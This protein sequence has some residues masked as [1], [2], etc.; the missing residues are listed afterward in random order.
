MRLKVLV[1]IVTMCFA[2]T[3]FA[4]GPKLTDQ[5]IKAS[6]EKQNSDADIDIIKIKLG[7][8]N[9][10][11]NNSINGAD[12]NAGRMSQQYY[13]VYQA[14]ANAGVIAISKD[15]SYQKFKSGGNFN[16]MDYNS[17]IQ[18]VSDKIVVTKTSEGES[19]VGDLPQEDGWL[20]IR[21]AKFK[22]N[23]II[24][25]RSV[26][27]GIDNYCVVRVTYSAHWAPELK[28]WTETLGGHLSDQRKAIIL[29]KWDPFSSTWKAIAQDYANIDR[30]ITTNNVSK[31]LDE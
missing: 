12:L 17:S 25:I 24:E 14:W 23:K 8:F 28:H 10:V 6:I 20:T 3:V 16:W 21:V 11:S 31:A 13:K 26:Q 27:K 30:D 18:G 9:V 2:V 5:E 22:L 7:S 19:L 4:K 15:Q 29:F 1:A